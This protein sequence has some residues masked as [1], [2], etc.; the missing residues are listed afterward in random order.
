[1]EETVDERLKR[2]G[3]VGFERYYEVLDGGK[4]L[5]VR[6]PKADLKADRALVSKV[7]GHHQLTV[8]QGKGKL[9]LRRKV[10]NPDDYVLEYDVV[11][12]DAEA[13]A[14]RPADAGEE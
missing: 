10:E 3:I 1:M 2:L 8:L 5:R 14:G 9:V 7:F 13:M 12:A 11:P 4:V 6:L